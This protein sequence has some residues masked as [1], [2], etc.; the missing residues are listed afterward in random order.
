MS[1]SSW[2]LILLLTTVYMLAMFPFSWQSPLSQL[3]FIFYTTLSI[4][5]MILSRTKISKFES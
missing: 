2:I 3:A 1:D 4:I 5:E